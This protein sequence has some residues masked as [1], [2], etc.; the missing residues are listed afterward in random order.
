M[1]TFGYELIISFYQDIVAQL[2]RCGPIDQRHPKMIMHYKNI[3]NSK[4]FIIIEI[5]LIEFSNN[6]LIKIDLYIYDS[7]YTLA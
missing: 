4:V 2:H 7:N 1:T 3:Y 5:P 6:A